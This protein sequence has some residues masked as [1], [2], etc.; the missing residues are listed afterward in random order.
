MEYSSNVIRNL[1]ALGLLYATSSCL[2]ESPSPI[3]II[4]SQK[5]LVVNG[6][7]SPDAPLLISV[8]NNI[9]FTTT[10]LAL[11]NIPDARVELWEGGQKLEEGTFQPSATVTVGLPEIEKKFPNHFAYRAFFAFESVPEAG[12]SYSLKVNAP[13]YPAV[14]TT[15]R[16]PEN[17]AEAP[18]FRIL[19]I[20]RA[21]GLIT[22]E[23]DLELL[24]E[25]NYFH[26]QFF[27]RT[28]GFNDVEQVEQVKVVLDNEGLLNVDNNGVA[29]EGGLNS[30]IMY[31]P[32]VFG[33]KSNKRIIVLE[34]LSV[35]FFPEIQYELSAEL[36]T[37][38]KSYYDY[39]VAVIQQKY[40]GDYPFVTSI[41]I[42]NNVQ[43]G[44]GNFS[45]FTSRKSGWLDLK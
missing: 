19:S 26:L 42:P 6:H 24:D 37:I 12:K 2:F 13:G 14:E 44:L 11:Q 39:Y 4:D 33:S 15:D 36:R 18:T 31:N 29:F 32:N 38:S 35:I 16:V 3:E 9:P 21:N 1:A 25:K 23:V 7:I 30:G 45:A 5:K 43:G 27:V 34:Y 40:Y 20:N 41:R 10:M 28:N 8:T 17:A 22:V